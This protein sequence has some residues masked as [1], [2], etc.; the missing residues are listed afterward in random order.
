MVG[1]GR[2]QPR[3][4]AA[5]RILVVDDEALLR[6]CVAEQLRTVGYTVIEAANADEALAALCRDDV[7]LVFSDIQMPGSMN[8][9]DLARVIRSRF[10][11]I[12]VVL[13][14][15][16]VAAVNDGEHDGFF[17]K[18]YDTATVIDH[19]KALVD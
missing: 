19:I 4:D 12:K 1:A 3:E 9:A 11:M 5:R 18:P 15:G 10:P 16:V 17:P 2:S 14:S 6:I 7:H 13:T 8:G